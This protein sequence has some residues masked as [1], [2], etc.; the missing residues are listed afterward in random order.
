[1]SPDLEATLVKLA[2]PCLVIV[3]VLAV[4]RWRRVTWKD[5]L[6]L[7][8][9]RPSVMATWLAIWI[10]WVVVGEFAIRVFGL[11]QAEPWKPYPLLI[12]LL[13]I[14]A[15]GLLGPAAEEI[16]VRGVLFFRIGGT[17]LGPVGAIVIGAA[18]WAAAHFQYD[19][20]TRVMIFLDGLV[21]GTARLR[22]R[23]V[24]VPIVMHALGNL[25][26]IQQS[27]TGGP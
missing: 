9:P 18:G 7:V 8:W 21:L 23:S 3:A 16:V 4:A 26:S 13:R 5:D 12:I 19:A 6:G 22:S 14:A 2:L 1:M 10:G 25:Y 20:A 15:I 27:L 17:R 11:A 24:Y